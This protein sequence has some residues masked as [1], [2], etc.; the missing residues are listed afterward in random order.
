MDLVSIPPLVIKPRP[1]DEDECGGFY[2]VI[3]IETKMFSSTDSSLF[4]VQHTLYE[5]DIEEPITSLP[6]SSQIVEFPVLFIT[7]LPA[8]CILT[9]NSILYRYNLFAN[10]TIIP[11]NDSYPHITIFNYTDETITINH[12]TTSCQI[13]LAANPIY[14]TTQS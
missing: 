12:L 10:I 5:L 8:L 1:R 13:V 9:V 14:T 11:T 4:K 7:A 3:R 6:N 2:P